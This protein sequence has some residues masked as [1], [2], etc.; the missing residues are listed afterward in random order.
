MFL[1]T[2]FGEPKPWTPE[3][4]QMLLLELRRDLDNRKIH[5]YRLGKRVWAQKPDNAE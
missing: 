5:V 3:E 2:H 4:V 1:L